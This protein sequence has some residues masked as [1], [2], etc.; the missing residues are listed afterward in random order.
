MQIRRVLFILTLILVCV[1]PALG[2]NFQVDC[3]QP[4]QKLA[5]VLAAASPGDTIRIRGL[6]KET[7]TITTDQL[8][9]EGDE[10][11]VLDG[12]GPIRTC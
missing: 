7:V 2:E 10:T 11:A 6:C 4:T 9:L 1:G 8:T 12:N 3:T 5:P